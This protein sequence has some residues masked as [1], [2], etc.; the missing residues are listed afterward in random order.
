MKVT[1]GHRVQ[2]HSTAKGIYLERKHLGHVKNES[3]VYQCQYN[4]EQI[5]GC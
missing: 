1:S 5:K 4:I 2:Q 3:I